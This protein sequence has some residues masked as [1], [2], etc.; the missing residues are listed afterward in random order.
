MPDDPFPP[1][2]SGR[3]RRFTSGRR[4][5]RQAEGF[6]HRH[7]RPP[8]SRRQ[9]LP[10]RRRQSLVRGLAGLAGRLWRPSAAATRTGQVEEPG[11]H[12]S[13]RAGLGRAVAGQGGAGPHL[14]G[15]R[16]GLQRRP[17]DRPG[18]AAG[19]DGQARH[20]GGDLRQQLLGLVGRHA[21]LS[22]LDRQWDL[23]PA[24]RSGPSLAAVRRLFGPLLR[25]RQGPGPVPPLCEDPGRAAPIR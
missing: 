24:G 11:R 2:A 16:R 19:R 18:R 8:D 4:G 1:R 9:A 20:E 25:R 5:D 13:A 22:E 10:V 7:R 14:P 3:P 17:A 12:Q 15:S 6:R 21:G 23:V